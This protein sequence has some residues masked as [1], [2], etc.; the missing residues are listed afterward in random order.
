CPDR[1]GVLG[2]G[3]PDFD[4]TM[5]FAKED[6][7]VGWE[8]ELDRLGKICSERYFAEM[9]IVCGR[10]TPVQAERP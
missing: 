3:F 4:G 7:A 9:G 10:G 1:S 6:S 8:G 2:G 5:A